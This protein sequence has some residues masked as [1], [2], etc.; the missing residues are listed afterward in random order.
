MGYLFLIPLL[1]LNINAE[2]LIQ[3]AIGGLEG[4]YTQRLLSLLVN[5][6]ETKPKE[7]APPFDAVE[8]SC[9]K[10]PEKKNYVGAIQKM[11]IRAPLTKV[12][13][14]LKDID[15][16]QPIFSGFKEIKVQSKDQNRW[17]TFWEQIVPVFFLPNIKYEMVYLLS[18]P[19]PKQRVF[20]YQLKEATGDLHSSDGF[21]LLEAES[22]EVTRFIEYDIFSGSFGILSF[23][24]P[25]RI[26]EEALKGFYLSDAAIRIKAEKNL[27]DEKIRE[28]ANQEWETVNLERLLEQ[29]Q[30]LHP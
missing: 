12:D 11:R 13:S 4:E 15:R 27:P 23:I 8:L 26:W 25:S 16:Y 14:L 7:N 30:V 28:L 22:N 20:R 6:M 21:I 29:C 17:I 1:I 24:S 18:D 10:H 5:H 19:N 2:H 3:G 9:L